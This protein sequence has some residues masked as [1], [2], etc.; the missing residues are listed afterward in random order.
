M[1]ACGFHPQLKPPHRD[2][3]LQKLAIKQHENIQ[4]PGR[5]YK[6]QSGGANWNLPALFFRSIKTATLHLNVDLRM[7]VLLRPPA[8]F[9]ATGQTG[10]DEERPAADS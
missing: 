8:S 5:R 9:T 7:Q 2:S 1:R 10:V 4:L 3:R 6:R